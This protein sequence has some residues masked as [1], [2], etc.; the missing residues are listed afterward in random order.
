MFHCENQVC[1]KDYNKMQRVWTTMTEIQI[2]LFKKTELHNKFS[3]IL[4]IIQWQ[5]YKMHIKSRCYRLQTHLLAY[6]MNQSHHWEANWFLVSQ[7]FPRNLWNPKVHY[8][9]HKCSPPVPILI[10]IDPVHAMSHFLKVHLIILPSMLGSSKWFLSLRFSN[11]NR[12][13]I[14]PPPIRATCLAHLILLDLITQTVLGGEYR[15]LS[16]SLCSF[17]RSPVTSSLLGTNILLN[18]LFSNTLSLRSSL[19]VI[20]QVSHP[21]KTTGK[22]I[23]LFIYIRKL[24]CKNVPN[25]D[26]S[27]TTLCTTLFNNFSYYY[28]YSI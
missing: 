4:Y 22:I 20:D 27:Y 25:I 26:T 17:L 16:S 15:T 12:A 21:Y 23:A 5:Y 19:N 10:Q 11:Q 9:I 6:C 1:L 24:F 13:Y 3:G 8:C 7:E 18:T 14:T 2:S 28:Q